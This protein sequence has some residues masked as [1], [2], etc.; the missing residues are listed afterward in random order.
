MFETLRSRSIPI[1]QAPEFV[2][3]W[4]GALEPHWNRLQQFATPYAERA[5]DWYDKREPREKLLLRVLAIIAGLIILYDLIYVPV[6]GLR[7]S[8]IASVSAR[9]NDLVAVRQMM[10]SY[11]RLQ[12]ELSAA[13]KRTLPDSKDF[14]L[15]GVLEET[16]TRTVGRDK[17]G[18]ITPG[19]RS[20]EGGFTQYTVDVKLNN[21]SLPQ[22]VDAL[23]GVQTLRVPISVS[24]LQIRQHSENSHSYDVNLTCMALGKQG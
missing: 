1:P 4:I 17:I 16:L 5:A 11:D 8:V 2:R 21:I 3:R 6:I 20:V 23:Y 10:H 24:N 9:R 14:S 15:F 19:Q 22:V 12:L 18:S 7:S 13:E